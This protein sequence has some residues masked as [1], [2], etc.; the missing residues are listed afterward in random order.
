MALVKKYN[1]F[2]RHDE[3]MPKIW[4]KLVFL[5]NILILS[6]HDLIKLL[7]RNI[8]DEKLKFTYHTDSFKSFPSVF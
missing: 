2:F 3:T 1:I 6:I 8:Q 4:Q 5:Y 7:K